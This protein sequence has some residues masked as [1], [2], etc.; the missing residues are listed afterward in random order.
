MDKKEFNRIVKEVFTQYGFKKK[1]DRYM[2]LFDEVMISCQLYTWNGVRSFNYWVSINAVYDDSVPLEKRG[3]SYVCIK[4]DHSPEAVGYHK[5]EI[6]YEEYDEEECRRI[7][8]YLLHTYFDPYKQ[9]ATQYVK[10]NHEWLTIRP[11]GLKCLG[12]EP[13]PVRRRH[14]LRPDSE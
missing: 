9:D 14:P 3:D 8:N 1:R 4:M 7:L 10:D 6:V 11:E 5:A 2:L 12:I 13:P